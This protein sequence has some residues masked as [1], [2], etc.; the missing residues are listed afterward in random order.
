MSEDN[1][2]Q[3]SNFEKMISKV[4]RAELRRM[5]VKLMKWRVIS[6]TVVLIFIAFMQVYLKKR[7]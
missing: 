3:Y 7:L 4:V 6:Y 5:I 2:R 1:N